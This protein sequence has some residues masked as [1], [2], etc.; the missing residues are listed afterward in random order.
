VA[1]SL[2]PQKAGDRVNTD[3]RDAVH[4]ARLLRSGDLTPV[5][6]P[7][8]ADEA[9]RDLSRARADARRDL[10]TAKC[11]LNA[12]L[13]RQDLRSTGQATWSP[14]HRRG[15]AAV[16]CPPPAPQMV[17]QADVRA[18]TDHPER[19]QRLDQARHAPGNTWRLAP[20]VEARQAL[21]GVPCTVAVTIVAARGDLTRVDTPRQ[22]M[23]DLGL[24]PSAYASGERRRQGGIT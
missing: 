12:F 9:L 17:F 13:R 4:W 2:I 21:R 5:D 8:G 15:L 14:A 7:P 19:L 6:V 10:Q 22:R 1:P 16:V 18:V 3:R 23:S 20:G 11:R 24:T